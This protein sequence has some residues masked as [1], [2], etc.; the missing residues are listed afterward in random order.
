MHGRKEFLD[1]YHQIFKRLVRWEKL[2]YNEHGYCV[3]PAGHLSLYVRYGYRNGR[4]VVN[5]FKDGEKR[6]NRLFIDGC[7]I[8]KI[9]PDI[10]FL[11]LLYNLVHRVYHYYDNS[12]GILS[13]E[14]IV[15]KA[16]DVMSYD[17][18]LM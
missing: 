18:S 13:N 17:V 12:D 9:K 4:C 15:Q 16:I 11:E 5:R 14:L 8:R 2:E 10:T 3:I 6:R 1:F 7:I